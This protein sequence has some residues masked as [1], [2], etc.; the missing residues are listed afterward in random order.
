MILPSPVSGAPALGAVLQIP[1]RICT[2][3][4]GWVSAND[5]LPLSPAAPPPH[6]PTR[7]QPSTGARSPALCVARFDFHCGSALHYLNTYNV[8]AHIVHCHDWQSAAIAWGN[9]GSARCVFTIHN[10]S[11]GADL[12]GRA[13][14]A[15]DVA[16]TVSPTYAREVGVYGRVYAH[17]CVCV[18]AQ[19]WSGEHVVRLRSKYVC[20]TLPCVCATA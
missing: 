12:V 2:S 3:A 6:C 9:R 18:R 10:L 15:C 4:R 14:G 11:Y 17:V 8:Q 16:T 13:M 19:L 20:A 5:A 1:T 7:L